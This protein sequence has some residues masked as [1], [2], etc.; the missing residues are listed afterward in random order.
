MFDLRGGVFLSD[1]WEME[2]ND[3]GANITRE[4]K[5]VYL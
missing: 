1:P 2:Q 3:D 5:M 4:R